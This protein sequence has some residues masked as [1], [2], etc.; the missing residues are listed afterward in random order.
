MDSFT[1]SSADEG[2][3]DLQPEDSDGEDDVSSGAKAQLTQDQKVNYVQEKRMSQQYVKEKMYNEFVFSFRSWN[4]WLPSTL[5]LLL[6]LKVNL[7]FS[8]D[9]TCSRG[10]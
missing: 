10:M 4:S 2:L 5:S 6:F 3:A 7:Y 1:L 9:N 8:M